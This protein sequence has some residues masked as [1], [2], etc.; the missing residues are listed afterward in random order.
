VVRRKFAYSDNSSSEVGT[1]I[2]IYRFLRL[3]N[4]CLYFEIRTTNWDTRSRA[5]STL[6]VGRGWNK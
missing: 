1:E 2:L 6:A 5:G 3:S 4:E